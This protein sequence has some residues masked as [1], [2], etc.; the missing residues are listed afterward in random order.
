MTDRLL[1]AIRADLEAAG[2]TVGGAKRRKVAGGALKRPEQITLYRDRNGAIHCYR[3]D[4]FQDTRQKCIEVCTAR[5]LVQ[6]G[7]TGI[8]HTK[9]TP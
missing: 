3:N 4:V 7:D 2:Y 8:W 5:G 1:T 9:E 6:V